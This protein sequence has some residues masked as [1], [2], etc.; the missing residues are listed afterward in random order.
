MAAKSP[1]DAAKSRWIYIGF[2]QITWISMTL[3]GVLMNVFLP[4][5]T[6]PEQ[7]LPI[8]TSIHLHPMLAE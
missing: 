7:A 6:D 3:F 8:F 5:I 4:D 2:M 1:N